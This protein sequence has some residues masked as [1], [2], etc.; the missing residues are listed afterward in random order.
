MWNDM[1]K[2]IKVFK[3]LHILVRDLNKIDRKPGDYIFG[4]CNK[5]KRRLTDYFFTI[6]DEG[7]ASSENGSLFTQLKENATLIKH[8]GPIL[9]IL[10]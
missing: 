3:E 9:G 7:T 2:K 5:F 8:F 6:L 10:L 4:I 1:S